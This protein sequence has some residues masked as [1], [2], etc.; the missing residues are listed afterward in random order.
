MV[1]IRE[2]KANDIAAIQKRQ[3]EQY[4]FSCPK[5]ILENWIGVKGHF[6]FADPE[7]FMF[8]EYVRDLRPMPFVHRAFDG[9]GKIAYISEV[10]FSE[11]SEDSMQRLFVAAMQKAKADGCNLVA[12]VTGNDGDHDRREV[13]FLVENGFVRGDIIPRWEAKPGHFVSDHSSWTKR[14]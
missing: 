3:M 4:G 13:A 2:A 9:V 7:T 10:G 5:E 14:L 1:Y 8:F 12:W 11:Q 6:L